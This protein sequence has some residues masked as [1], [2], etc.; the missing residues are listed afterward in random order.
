[1]DEP[2]RV[3]NSLCSCGEPK[4][5]HSCLELSGEML[6]DL[7]DSH[8]LWMLEDERFD[9]SASFYEP[10]PDLSLL[11]WDTREERDRHVHHTRRCQLITESPA[12]QKRN[13]ITKHKI[14]LLANSRIYIGFP[15]M[16][17]AWRWK[18]CDFSAFFGAYAWLSFVRHKLTQETNNVR[19]LL[20]CPDPYPRQQR[21]RWVPGSG[22]VSEIR[23]IH[24]LTW[25]HPERWQESRSAKN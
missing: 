18:I 3:R 12:H 5:E 24:V 4:E 25:R 1:M 9:F 16:L 22:S 23:T 6:L 21:R 19:S 20:I 8:V 13:D 11:F 17:N 7:T 2:S 15:C 14:S 10:K